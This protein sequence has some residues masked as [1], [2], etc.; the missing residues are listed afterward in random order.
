MAAYLQGTAF[1]FDP[2]ALHDAGDIH[3]YKCDE[4]KARWVNFGE[5]PLTPVFKGI[6]TPM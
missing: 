5:V 4:G 6:R 1:K 3:A 2:F